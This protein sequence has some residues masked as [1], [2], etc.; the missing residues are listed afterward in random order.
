ML[1]FTDNIINTLT[2]MAIMTENYFGILANDK[3]ILLKK[4]YSFS[5]WD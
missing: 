2:P 4:I 5:S 1:K 3:D